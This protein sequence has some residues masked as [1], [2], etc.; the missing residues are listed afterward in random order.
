MGLGDLLRSGADALAAVSG[1]IVWVVIYHSASAGGTSYEASSD[2]HSRPSTSYPG[3]KLRL[4]SFA[5]REVDGETV[6]PGDRRALILP[7]V[8]PSGVNPKHTDWVV[9]ASGIRWEIKSVASDPSD[10]VWVL[11]LRR[12]GT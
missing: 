4:G 1:N 7:R 6:K 5:A 9:D 3:T 10:S 2:R 8:L 12:A 11:H